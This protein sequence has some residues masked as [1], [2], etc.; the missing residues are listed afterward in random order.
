MVS[1]VPVDIVSRCSPAI[2]LR[3]KGM[4]RMVDHK[5]EKNPDP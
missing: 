4:S 5:D 3:M 1:L 2:C